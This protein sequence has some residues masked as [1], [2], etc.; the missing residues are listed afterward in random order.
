MTERTKT[1][2]KKAEPKKKGPKYRAGRTMTLP[3]SQHFV[4]GDALPDSVE[5]LSNFKDCLAD[6]TIV[7]DGDDLPPDPDHIREARARGI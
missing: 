6:K 5:R 7:E 4:R 1:E 2:E 3:P